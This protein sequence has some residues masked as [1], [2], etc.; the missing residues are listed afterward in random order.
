MQTFL[1]STEHAKWL[2]D[3][4]A[5]DIEDLDYENLVLEYT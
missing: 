3:S 2:T 1:E 5:L 4:K